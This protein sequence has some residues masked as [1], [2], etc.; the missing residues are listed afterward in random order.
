MRLNGN[1]PALNRN[2]QGYKY[3]NSSLTG[4]QT[5]RHCNKNPTHVSLRNR[6]G[7]AEVQERP[8]EFRDG[9]ARCA[10]RLMGS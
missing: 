10:N 8:V 5:Q 7:K 2:S 1:K 4:E 6:N 3:L 9:G